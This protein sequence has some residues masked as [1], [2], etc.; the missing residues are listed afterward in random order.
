VVQIEQLTPLRR[1]PE[2]ITAHN[3]RQFGGKA[4]APEAHSALADR[5]PDE[6][7]S[8]LA[9][10]LDHLQGKCFLTVRLTKRDNH[11]RIRNGYI[12][13]CG[14]PSKAPAPD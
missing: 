5:K 1:G 3:G 2:S 8:I 4:K 14:V 7:A 13:P 11:D 9:R 6:Y 12:L 10:P